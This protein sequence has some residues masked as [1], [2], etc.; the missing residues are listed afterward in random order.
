MAS[1]GFVEDGRSIE[2]GGVP[3]A[4]GMMIPGQNMSMA[5]AM[6]G[7]NGG[8]PVFYSPAATLG[9]QQVNLSS[10]LLCLHGQP[11]PTC[12]CVY[13]LIVDG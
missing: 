8:G 9:G 12:V 3:G 11:N 4:G 6:L 1:L 13:I 7:R 2:Q 5:A 10:S